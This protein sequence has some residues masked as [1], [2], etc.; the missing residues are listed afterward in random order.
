MKSTYPK[1]AKTMFAASLKNGL[2]DEAQGKQILSLVTRRKPQ[3]LLK[4]LRLYKNLVD[5]AQNK[6]KVTIQSAAKLDRQT[7]TRISAKTHTRKIA[8]TV[9]PRLVFGTRITHGDWVW[10]N[11]LEGKLE[12]LTANQ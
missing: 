10:D 3:G 1:I 8:V 11:T 6:E 7:L 2:V 9:N 4:T 5:S 12:Q